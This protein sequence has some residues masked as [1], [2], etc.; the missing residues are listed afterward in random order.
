M[1]THIYTCLILEQGNRRMTFEA[2]Q[3][4]SFGTDKTRFVHVLLVLLNPEPAQNK[5][6]T[7]SKEVWV[8]ALVPPLDRLGQSP[9]VKT[10]EMFAVTPLALTPLIIT[11]T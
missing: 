8:V 11:I 4:L 2:P 5:K 6:T 1:Y 10:H 3:S 9:S 7:K